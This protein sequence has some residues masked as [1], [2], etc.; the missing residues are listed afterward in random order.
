MLLKG[1][2]KEEAFRIGK[3]IVE[4]V[5][6]DNPKPV[7]LKF[8]KVLSQFIY[9]HNDQLLCRSIFHVCYRLRNV[10][11]VMLMSL[12]TSKSQYL[13]QRELRRSVVMA[14]LLLSRYTTP[15]SF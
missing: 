6:A 15:I 5:I 10:M 2:T 3:E 8:E 7:K 1:T 14:A 9:S 4:A 11:L 12:R 13:M